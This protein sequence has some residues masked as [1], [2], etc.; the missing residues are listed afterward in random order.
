MPLAIDSVGQKVWGNEPE[1]PL[2]GFDFIPMWVADMNFS[3]CPS[4]TEAITK[5][6]EHPAFG[7]FRPSEEY[8]ASIIKWQE[9]PFRREWP[10][11]R[12]YRL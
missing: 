8:Y 11:E 1:Q 7:Y 2:D 5:R 10:E 9:K 3:T 4:V 12:A 6:V